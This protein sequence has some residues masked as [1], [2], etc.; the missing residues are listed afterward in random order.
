VIP[1]FFY[2][3][4]NLGV[5]FS[6]LHNLREVN[7]NGGSVVAVN[8]SRVSAFNWLLIILATVDIMLIAFTV[9]DYTIVR[10]W[11]VSYVVLMVAI[12]Q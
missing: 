8:T 11:K 9:I 12:K 4:L 10:Q 2:S 1:Q 6:V 7:G 5:V 3:F